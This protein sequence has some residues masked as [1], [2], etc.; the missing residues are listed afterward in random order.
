M[1]KGSL[2]RY[3][4]IQEWDQKLKKKVWNKYQIKRSIRENK[5]NDI[6]LRKRENRKNIFKS[7]RNDRDRKLV[8]KKGPIYV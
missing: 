6:A 2:K 4:K 7:R 8:R 5:H 3:N 1:N